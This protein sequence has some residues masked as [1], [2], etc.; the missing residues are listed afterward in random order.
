MQERPRQ[1]VILAGG[2]GERLRPLTDTRPKHLVEVG[3]R[4]FL[5][6]L[7]RL[8]SEQGFDRVLLLLGYL[9]QATVDFIGNGQRYG[10]RLEYRK[11]PADWQTSLRLR[12]AQPHLDQRFLLLY[13]DNYWPM[14]FLRMWDSYRAGGAPAQI[15]V[16]ENTDGW[17]RSNV[18][19]EHDG[20]VIRY[21]KTRL[22][23]DL[24]GVD[25]GFA[26]LDRGSLDVLPDGNV[27][28]EAALY[29]AL[30]AQGKL[31]AFP[32][33]HRYY[34]VGT[35]ERLAL[36]AE[37]LNS[38]PTVI[39]DRDGVLNRKPAIGAYVRSWDDWEWLP[40][41]LEALRLLHEAGWRVLVATNQAG[42][43]RGALRA[44]ELTEI[45]RRMQQQARRAGGKIE[46]VYCCPHGWDAGC[47]CRK[48]AP[49]LL[50]Q[51]QKDFHLDLSRTWFLGDDE[52]D[53]QA[54]EKAGCRFAMVDQQNP[55]L[56]CASRWTQ[57]VEEEACL[58]V[59]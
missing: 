6:H 49:G 8:L 3:G 57:A 38:R 51:A 23:A 53:A 52:R 42:V 10:A 44:T 16:Y 35:P 19:F 9:P 31:R 14:P 30:A 54:A 48:P 58:S 7:L 2:R 56:A 20:R 26:L 25:I 27:P 55:L 45:H 13:C 50:F 29:P 39:L 11:T 47:G 40:G 28:V 15:T 41:S 18:R 17:S 33:K 37:F 46:A 5:D 22:A 59:C 1:A 36:T 34:G 12:D 21:D 43:A 4:P 24:N 32:T